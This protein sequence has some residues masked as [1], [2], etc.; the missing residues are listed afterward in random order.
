MNRTFF[1]MT[2][3]AIAIFY[4]SFACGQGNDNA[5]NSIV[6]KLTGFLENHPAEKAYLQFDKPYY[7]AGDT[8]YFKAYVTAGEQHKLSNISGVLHVDLINAKNKI[9]QSLNLQLDTGIAWG[10]FALPDSLPTANYRVR[11]YT[12]WMRNE[13]ETAFFS[14]VIPVLSEKTARIPES[15]MKQTGQA[16]NLKPDV[17]F[18]PEGGA[19]VSGIASKVAFKALGA[20]G[21]GV[22]IKGTVVDNDGNKIISFESINRGMGY[23]Y[24]N[25][26]QGKTYRA[27]VAYSNG[28]RDSIGLPKAEQSGLTLSIDN[29]SLP[30]AS[31]KIEANGPYYLENRGKDYTL[32]IYSGGTTAR[33][34][35]KLD[36]AVIKLDVLKRKLHTGV[37]TVTIFSP[38]N[39]PLCER[40]LFIQNYDRL[41][42][43]V[44]SDKSGYLKRER[45]NV[46]LSAINRKGSPAE[47]H[48]SASV[49]DERKVPETG[50]NSDN[51]LTYFV[52][53]SDLKGCIE[54]PDYY[55][56]DTGMTVRTNLDILMLTQ[57]YRRF[58]WKRVLDTARRS[59]AYQPEKGIEIAGQVK[60]LFGKPI[61]NGAVTLI[62]EYKGPVFTSKTDDK[63]M[64]HFSN[65]VFADTAHFVLSAVNAKNKNSTKIIYFDQ[66][67]SGPAVAGKRSPV[68]S[69]VP[70]TAIASF[71]NND[72]LQ[73]AE[74]VK[75]GH[76]KGIMLREVKI[77]DKKQD[78]QY[79]TQSF[80]GAG[81]ADQVMHADEIERVQGPLI[82]SLDGRLR[83]VTFIGHG[84]ARRPYKML[85]II[86]GAE[87]PPDE[88]NSLS[89]ADVETVEVLKYASASIYGVQGAGGV[90]VITTKQ[91]R[92]REP[93][94]IAS[95]GVLP[96]SPVGF[97][98]AR[99]FY[100]PKYDNPNLIAKQRDLRS[101]V[102]WK[103]EIKTDKDG[104][105]SFE[106]YNADG[107]GTYKIVV[108]GID[109]NGNIGRQ[110][111]RYKVE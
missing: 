14:K 47:G 85:L 83:G 37:A 18:F 68:I 108:E 92:G 110:V 8:I 94:D 36:S 13:D 31:V 66:K 35:F 87:L 72:K 88:I 76:I 81:H 5:P 17:Q 4:C 46:R 69:I 27:N 57:G 77:K 1:T 109:N 42:L 86:D 84:L 45:V 78:N 54:Q 90:L 101:T 79:R 100:S 9:D 22:Q 99:E 25:P 62:S 20:N 56:A 75:Y 52:L 91:G 19:L 15:L 60:S 33:V 96:I 21:S 32:V 10:D 26:Q 71:V 104:N 95:V 44:S 103:P 53:S 2:F 70:D 6:A 49:I 34:G 64:F 28:A 89:A 29:D 59:L 16:S 93:K 51:I 82:T 50:N 63:G 74:L 40:L 58:T 73:Q 3:T 97:Y 7:A 105:A 65:L 111:Y 12:R 11:A 61:A 23:F 102:Y 30:K 80:A 107:A 55:F 41:S 98:K 24:L 43:N 38:E 106:Y 48:F 39:E 67:D